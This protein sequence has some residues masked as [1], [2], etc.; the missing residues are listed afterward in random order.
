MVK[1][2]KI[3]FTEDGK[4]IGFNEHAILMPV[5]VI[6]KLY[7]NLRDES[8]EETAQ[9]MLKDIGVF[10]TNQALK[11]YVKT[12]GIKDVEKEKIFEFVRNVLAVLGIGYFNINQNGESYTISIKKTAFAEEYKLEY[13]VQ[14]TPID[15][16]VSGIWEAGISAIAG[17]QMDCSEKKC[18]AK[19]DECCEFSLKPKK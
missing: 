10:Q 15:F 12:L 2:G 5:R 17:K 18:F 11:R 9:R 1:E 7:V 19:G 4:I 16:Y 8:G 13:G 3:D 6:N 14:K